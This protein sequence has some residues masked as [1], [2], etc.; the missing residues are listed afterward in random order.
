[1]IFLPST[2]VLSRRGW[3]CVDNLPTKWQGRDWKIV[4]K[5][6]EWEGDMDIK[7]HLLIINYY[8]RKLNIII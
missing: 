3:G 4:S 5:S 2:Q 1:M 8:Y 6:N 7:D